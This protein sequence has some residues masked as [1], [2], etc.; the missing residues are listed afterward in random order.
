[1][2]RQLGSYTL[3][4]LSGANFFVTCA[5]YRFIQPINHLNKSQDKTY[6][7]KTECFQ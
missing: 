4:L 3:Y 2:M 5:T 7:I 1:M 6:D